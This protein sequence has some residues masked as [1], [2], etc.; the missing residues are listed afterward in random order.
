MAAKEN[1]PEAKKSENKGGKKRFNIIRYFKEMIG[2][3]KKLT[4]LTKSE[5]VSHTVV[6][7]VFVI[8][9][10]IIIYVLD[11]LFGT[12]IGA[13]ESIKIG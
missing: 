10:A 12:G 3:V 4:W 13:L 2:E 6:V 1:K 5:L 9:M 11:F 8:V 7:F